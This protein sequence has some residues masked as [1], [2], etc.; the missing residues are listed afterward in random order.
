[1]ERSPWH[2]AAS[3]ASFGYD[4]I[5]RR[6]RGLNSARPYRSS[7]SG[8]PTDTVMVRLSGSTNGPSTPESAGGSFGSSFGAVPRT[9]GRLVG[10]ESDRKYSARES[11]DNSKKKKKNT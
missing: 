2:S 6:W 9:E 1:M 3:S 8:A 4:G 11:R 10:Q 7:N 5:S